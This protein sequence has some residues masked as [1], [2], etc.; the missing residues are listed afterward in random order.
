MSFGIV[1]FNGFIADVDL[2]GAGEYNPYLIGLQVFGLT[3]ILSWIAMQA[4]GMASGL[5]GGV[6]SSA[7]SLRQIASGATAPIRGA[8][9]VVNG[10]TTRR[11]M[12]SGQMV[13]AG[14]L[15]HLAAGNTVWNPAYRQHVMQNLG[16]N[17]GKA[18]G[19]DVT[20]K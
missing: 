8:A 15:N 5:A 20:G 4:G 16:K 1:A 2:T 7:L 3:L 18:K 12:Q 10:Q 19:G 9:N 11:D 17:W 6:S 13:T 14:R